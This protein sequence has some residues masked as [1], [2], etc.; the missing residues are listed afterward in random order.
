MTALRST[1]G[2][3]TPEEYLAF[4]MESQHRH[5]F[6]G[7]RIYAMAGTTVIHGEIC[8]NIYAALHSQLRGKPCRPFFTEI[9]LKVRALS[10]EN[11][12]YPD[13]MVACDPADNAALW[14]ERPTVV[15]EVVSPSSARTDFEKFYIYQHVA[16]L[17]LYAIVEQDRSMVTTILRTADGWQRAHLT[18]PTAQLPLDAIGCQLSLAQIYEGI[19]FAAAK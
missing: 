9:K 18:D 6:V 12:Y 13:V 3:L 14:R 2:I 17:Q 15:F 8:G 16:T 19:D 4:E 1:D 10:E 11:Y 5:E 7:G